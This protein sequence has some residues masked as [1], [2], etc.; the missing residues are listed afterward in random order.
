MIKP[1]I[2][3]R[4]VKLPLSLSAKHFISPHHPTFMDATHVVT[5]NPHSNANSS[6]LAFRRLA[7]TPPLSP[8]FKCIYPF[9]PR[10]SIIKER[11]NKVIQVLVRSIKKVAKQRKVNYNETQGIGDWR[12][13]VATNLHYVAF[14]CVTRVKL[15][16]PRDLAILNIVLVFVLVHLI[17]SSTTHK[18]HLLLR[19]D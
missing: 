18:I 15:H 7:P 3:V 19:H 14:F 9:A 5:V 8:S 2:W 10:K 4:L 12:G 17:A 13:S 1:L 11:Q 6:P 16:S